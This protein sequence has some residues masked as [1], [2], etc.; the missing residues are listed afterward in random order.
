MSS[1]QLKRKTSKCFKSQ[2]KNLSTL[3]IVV[4]VFEKTETEKSLVMGTVRKTEVSSV[5][6]INVLPFILFMQ[7]PD[8]KIVSPYPIFSDRWKAGEYCGTQKR[9]GVE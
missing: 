5:S 9:D 6:G 3:I 4:P 1:Q 7:S 8:Y 2:G